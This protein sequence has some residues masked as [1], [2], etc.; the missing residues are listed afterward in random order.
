MGV[1]E[2]MRRDVAA[3]DENLFG[4]RDADRFPGSRELLRRRTPT[5]DGLHDGGLVVRRK[6][7]H[8]ADAYRARF[9]AA[10]N[11]APLVEAIDV[12]HRETERLLVE[13]HRRRE[14]VERFENGGAGIPRE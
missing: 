3:L 6:N 8:V 9:D 10:C 4:E 1:F 2:F 14:L 12:L 13:H 7:K 5:L 11:D